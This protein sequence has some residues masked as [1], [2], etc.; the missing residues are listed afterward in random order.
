MVNGVV[1]CNNCGAC[2]REV[3]FPPGVAQKHQIVRCMNCGLMYAYPRATANIANYEAA[4]QTREPMSL[5]TP[6]VIRSFDKLPDYEPIGLELRKLLPRGKAL[7]EVGCHAGVLLDRFRGQGWNVSGVDPDSR[8][9]N[10]ASSHYR[11]DVKA[12]TLED[13]GYD[14]ATF[15]AVVMLH[16]IEHLDDPAGT[17]GVIAR[18]LRPGGLLVVETPVYDTL[19]FRL[20][21]RRERSLSCDGHIV[22]Y[23]GGTLAALLE[24]CGFEIVAQRRVGRTMSLGRLLWNIGV[25]SKS[26]TL[27]HMIERASNALGLI[28]R[29][30][31]YL[32]TRDMVRIFARK[33]GSSEN[34]GDY[35][36]ARTLPSRATTTCGHEATTPKSSAG[37]SA[38]RKLL[39]IIKGDGSRF[40]RPAKAT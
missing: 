11:L 30:R 32:N 38:G 21:G 25:M 37:D 23:T 13:A 24:R 31:L 9:A 19:M 10:F 29:G 20:L 2:E 39:N 7:L 28:H 12:S 33:A 36:R 8:A 18:L 14:S 5:Q 35:R 16:V 6:E 15:D 17:V 34:H 40:G 3:V 27:Q 1:N 26:K 22:F 4:G